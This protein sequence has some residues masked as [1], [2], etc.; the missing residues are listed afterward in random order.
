MTIRLTK[1]PHSRSALLAVVL[2]AGGCGPSISTSVRYA[3]K[4]YGENELKQTKEGLTV[5]LTPLETLP[6][7]LTI[8]APVCSAS[9]QVVV[10]AATGKP[11]SSA[12]HLLRSDRGEVFPRVAITNSTDHVIRLNQAVVRLGDPAGNSYELM[13]K[14]D[15]IGLAASERPCVPGVGAAQLRTLK[16]LD[17]NVEIMPQ[18]TWK[19]YAVFGVPA[20]A[21]GQ[22]G[23]WKYAFYELPVTVDDTGRPTKTTRFEVRF[24]VKKFVDTF[25][26]SL[27]GDKK[28]LSSKEAD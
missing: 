5:E 8:Q 13:S 4:P 18:S 1:T 6:P 11:A 26:V 27:L 2:L 24:V 10:D 17:R 16:M 14:D 9:G 21:N 15:V 3:A 7:E 28:L 19:G 23:V 25:E 20:S 12:F 22:P